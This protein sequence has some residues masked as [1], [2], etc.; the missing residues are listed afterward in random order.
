MTEL[1]L[2][3][4]TV[5]GE[6]LWVEARGFETLGTL[7]SR[8]AAQEPTAVAPGAGMRLCVGSHIFADGDQQKWLGNLGLDDGMELTCVRVPDASA[9][10][11]ETAAAVA[12]APRPRPPP[13]AARPAF[14]G[15]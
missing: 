1:R 10:A 7:S 6:H 12:A 2:S 13:R 11:A 15:A 14:G 9:T 3:V 5:S 4:T 8:L